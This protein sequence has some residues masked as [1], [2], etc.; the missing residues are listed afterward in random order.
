MNYWLF[1]I[2]A[3]SAFTCWLCT[4]L[5][6]KIVLAGRII[7]NK[8][9]GNENSSL[10][11]RVASLAGSELLASSLISEKISD[12]NNLERLMP[13]IDAHVDEFL[14]HRLSKE[15]PMISMFIGNKTIE[16]LKGAF[17]GELKSIF[18]KI[19]AQLA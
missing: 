3:I 19:M 15:M 6:L 12:A 2:P 17:I 8:S 9:G 5:L 16:K 13:L 1:L 11:S 14:R 18:P 10:V 7:R 4:W